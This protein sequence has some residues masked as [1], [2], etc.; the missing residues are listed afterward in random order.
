[1][2]D[3]LCKSCGKGFKSDGDLGLHEYNAHDQTPLECKDCGKQSIGRQQFNNHNRKHKTQKQKVY[4][5]EMCQFEGNHAS[6]FQR[7][8]KLHNVIKEK[9]QKPKKSR[10]CA[11][12]GK[13]FDR[14]NSFDRHMINAHKESV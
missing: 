14:K 5:C 2:S 3:F 7:H 4:K 9:E 8:M 1:M 12:C 11:Q 13:M 10:N 6:N